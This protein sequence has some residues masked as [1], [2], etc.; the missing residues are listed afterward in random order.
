RGCPHGGRDARAGPMTAPWF[1]ADW[2]EP[3]GVPVLSIVRGGSGSGAR[4]GRFAHFNLGDHVG[5]DPVAVAENRRRLRLEAKLPAE[6]SW[7]SQV[8]GTA[9]VDLDA[10]EPKG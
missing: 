2:A 6:P 8:H 1:E 7:L 10:A 4:Q 5:D 3:P 9:V